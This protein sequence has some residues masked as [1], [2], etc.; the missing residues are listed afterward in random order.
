M[1]TTLT[2]ALVTLLCW[3]AAAERAVKPIPNPHASTGASSACLCPAQTISPDR[4]LFSPAPLQAASS[5][6][7]ETLKV[8]SVPVPVYRFKQP[9]SLSELELPFKIILQSSL[10]RAGLYDLPVADERATNSWF[11]G[12]RW[13]VLLCAGGCQDR[14]IQHI[15]WRFESR[16]DPAESFYALIV[17]TS[18]EQ[19]TAAGG[20]FTLEAFRNAISVGVPAPAWML[21]L[22]TTSGVAAKEL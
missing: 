19:Q 2:A 6:G 22:M 21:A 14:T 18:D 12:Y 7:V 15:G 8:G 9:R 1:R 5:L 17:K 4:V 10:P 13:S 20:V 3:A 16:S 11:E